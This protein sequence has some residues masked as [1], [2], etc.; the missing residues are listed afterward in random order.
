M[1]YSLTNP[2][3]GAVSGRIC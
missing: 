2:Q 3:I 1:V